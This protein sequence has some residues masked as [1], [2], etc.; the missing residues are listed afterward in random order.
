[1][2][3]APRQADSLARRA[4]IATWAVLLAV[5]LALCAWF[6]AFILLL[7]FAGI[8]FAIFLRAP[9]EWLNRTLKIPVGLAV[10]L[11]VL[12]M[13][14]ALGA[15]AWLMA[16]SLEGQIEKVRVE[17]PKS[18]EHARDQVKNTWIGRLLRNGFPP[19]QWDSMLGQAA[20]ILSS[21]V[22]VLVGFTIFVFVGVFVAINPEVYRDGLTR[23]VPRDR[24]DRVKEILVELGGRLRRWLFGRLI[25]MAF[26]GLAVTVGLWILKAPLALSLGL[27]AALCSFIPNLGPLLGAAP[28]VLLAM[29][30]G[31][32]QVALVVGLYVL[33][34][35]LDN[36]IVTP[37]I[38]QKAVHLPPALT[39]IAQVVAGFFF[40]VLGLFLATPLTACAV[41]L[42]RRLYVEDVLGERL[43]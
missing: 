19:I 14:A 40:G 2:D 12:G 11:V 6:G 23:L 21:A 36:N 7:T 1:M 27:I 34:E 25:G 42:V 28:G 15:A 18:I 13:L 4:F 24:R 30:Q 8:L 10:V 5:A 20:G 43:A 29:T 31:G 41:L 33:V 32:T 35:A 9:A 16:P 38:E 26:I 37:L 3:A 22:G 17:I 39:I